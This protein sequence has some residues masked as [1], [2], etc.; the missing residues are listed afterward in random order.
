MSEIKKYLNKADT[1]HTDN[2][3][4]PQDVPNLFQDET[5]LDNGGASS[6]GSI[7]GELVTRFLSR[8]PSRIGCCL[9]DFSNFYILSISC[10]KKLIVVSLIILL[11]FLYTNEKRSS[12]L[13]NNIQEIF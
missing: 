1:L 8:S 9:E 2:I 6:N 11:Y 10:L 7:L 4:E 3:G 13:K 5:N 12:N